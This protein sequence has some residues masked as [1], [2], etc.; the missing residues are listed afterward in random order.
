MVIVAGELESVAGGS[1]GAQAF[2][3][4]EPDADRT[5]LRRGFTEEWGSVRDV[6]AVDHAAC[7]E[8]ETSADGLLFGG[9]DVVR[10]ADV[11][12]NGHGGA[13]DVEGAALCVADESPILTGRVEAGDLDV[14]EGKIALL[15]VCA[16]IL[17]E[18]GEERAVVRCATLAAVGFSLI[19]EKALD[20][21]S[22]E[23]SDHAIVKTGWKPRAF[24]GMPRMRWGG[25]ASGF[26]GG[27]F[28]F[29]GGDRGVKV[30]LLVGELGSVGEGCEERGVV[31]ESVEG[32]PGIDGRSAP[33][34]V[35]EADGDVLFSGDLSAEE[36]G[37]R[38][39][40]GGGFRRALL[41]LTGDV[42][43][44]EIGA[45]FVY[46]EEAELRI[47]GSGDFLIGVFDG[48]CGWEA[49]EG[50]LHVGLA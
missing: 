9:M 27:V 26:C 38:G 43:K 20:G 44:R 8:G 6:L 7:G 48:G 18:C 24:K 41:P 1:V 10:V 42:L 31:A 15:E 35:D 32:D 29:F 5:G 23:R 14:K 22:G 50:H 21:F 36:V 16:P 19:P 3:V 47:G 13:V 34:G 46:D 25:F 17:Y 12:R 2:G 49:F 30:G 33:S 4:I 37:D 11:E 40:V 28:S 45:L 39:E